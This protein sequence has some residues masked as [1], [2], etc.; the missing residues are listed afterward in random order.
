MVSKEKM[1]GQFFTPRL[2]AEFM[3]DLNTKDADSRVL[4]PCAGKGA[5]L[6]VLANRNYSRIEAY[7]I[8]ED[9]ENLSDVPIVYSDFLRERI[10][11]EFDLVIGN[12]P[13]VRW[14]NLPK[15]VQSFLSTDS[16][17]RGRTNS[18]ADLLVTFIYAAVDALRDG[19]ELIFITPV[20]WTQTLHSAPLRRHLSSQGELNCLVNFNE[21]RIFE[22]VSSTI[23]VFKFTKTKFKSGAPITVVNLDSKEKL[24]RKHVKEVENLLSSL[25]KYGSYYNKGIYEA[26]LH[27]QFSDGRPWK[28]IPPQ[29][30]PF[31]EAIKKSC[32]ES[33]P[34]VECESLG[35]SR[36]ILLSRLLR[37]DDLEGLEIPPEACDIAGFADL[38]YFIPKLGV[39][40]L[41]SFSSKKEERRYVRLED[42]AH[43]G[44]GLV[45]G[46]DKAFTLK[47][48]TEY[49]HLEK[50]S[51]ISVVKAYDLHQYYA[52]GQT[53][54]LFLNAIEDE[55]QLRKQFPK[56]FIKLSSFKS[57]LEERYSYNRYI[58]WWHWVFLR[59]WDLFDKHDSKIFCPCKERI[60]KKGYARFSFVEGHFFPTQDVTGIVLKDWVREDPKYI[61]A[62]LNSEMI[63][64]YMKY[65]GLS[66]GGVLEFSEKP[67]S[68]IPIRLINWD[69]PKE[70]E[71][72]DRIVELVDAVL[73]SHDIGLHKKNIEDQLNQ[74][75]LPESPLSD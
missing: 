61:L 9:L 17:W 13:Y 26:Y 31:I 19:G 2:V 23:A 65:E 20:F 53:P 74:L 6:E 48:R 16:L 32:T 7:E 66:R 67:L 35:E 40:T 25:S 28:P 57:R 41:D 45:S 33:S 15:D 22:G 44:N 30:R 51:Y 42:I 62:L 73:V 34:V 8:D 75:V 60:D 69:I 29:H 11:A 50:D 1:Y 59:N 54:Y 63:L 5:F 70:R 47:D 10:T 46:L 3:L 38:K 27:P 21:M 36:M 71:T 56:A 49:G 58:P 37:N 64:T 55:E 18:L 43:I 12:P 39:R 52:S 24:Q 14:K 4:E 72:H 68:R